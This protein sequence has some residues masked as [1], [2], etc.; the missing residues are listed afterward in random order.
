MLK[1]LKKNLNLLSHRV[2][3]VPL[4]M[5][6]QITIISFMIFEFSRYF[7]LFYIIN[8]ILSLFLVLYIVNSNANPGYKIA[9]IIPI[10]AF[11]IFGLLLYSL[12]GGNQLTKRQKEKLKNIYY[13]Q[14]KYK[15]NHN[16]VLNE[17]KYENL[18]AHNQVKYIEN[19][20]LT[21]LCKHTKTTYLSNGQIYFNKLLEAIKNAK[22]YIFLE[23]FIIAEGKMWN[24][25]LETLKQK[26]SEGVDARLIYDDF[27]SIT[28]LPNNYDKKLEKLGIKTAIFNKFVPNLKSKFNNRDHRKIAVIDGNI[29]FTGGI[30]LAD[31]YIGEKIRF[32]HWKDNGIMLEGNAVWNFTVMF[33]SMWDYIKEENEDY[34][35]YKSISSS[36]TSSDGYVIPYSDSPW[37]NEAIGE[38]IYLNLI[39]KAN[40]YLYITTPYLVLDNEMITA[41][42]M[43]AKRG[44]DVHIITPGIPDKKTV[45][46]VTKA[47]YEILLKNGVQI[48]EYTKGFIH[49]KTFIVDDEYA[50]I[51]TVNLD[52]RS[53]YLHFECGVW[54]YDCSSIYTIKK[55][56][57]NILKES[58]EIKLKNLG[59]LNWFNSL[60]RQILK[61]L[62][63]L[64]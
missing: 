53:L 10:M 11:P 40:K 19:Y 33:L 7:V 25:I 43:A 37:D 9:W 12:F 6:I 15:D 42:N 56:Y 57:T 1:F 50:T 49:S 28:T 13:K 64:M 51:G 61:A 4:L 30:N 16:L 24:T 5:I 22:K 44:V 34:E 8:A 29:A 31:E 26:I 2:F 38:T 41:L 54:L 48:H 20:S 59:K 45:N 36:E 21:N 55:D 60:K 23:Y 47:Y 27:G 63:P 52:Y 17:L 14:L 58:K 46:E 3:L 39:N 35:K 62:A 18:S 32:G